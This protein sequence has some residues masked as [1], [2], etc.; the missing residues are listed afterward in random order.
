MKNSPLFLLGTLMIFLTLAMARPV[1]AQLEPDEELPPP[2]TEEELAQLLAPIA[3]YPDPL[4]S[5]ILMASTYP[6]EIV[7]AQRWIADNPGLSGEE[8][9]AHLVELDW[10]PSVK[11]LCHF[12]LILTMMSERLEQTADLGNAFLFQED[13]VMDVVQELRA[14]AHEAGNLADSSEQQVI[15]EEE[16]IIIEPA[17]PRVIYVP[18]YNPSFVYGRWRYPDYPPYYWVPGDMRVGSGIS[19]WPGHQFHFVFGSWSL[20][21]WPRRTLYVDPF[22]RPGFVRHDRWWRERDGWYH[23]PRYRRGSPFYRRPHLDSER[24]PYYRRDRFPDPKPTIVPP[25]RRPEPVPAYPPI[26]RHQSPPDYQENQQEWRRS[27]IIPQPQPP[28]VQPPRPR[29]ETVPVRPSVRRHQAPPDYQENQ[30]EWRRTVIIPQPQPTVV[31]PPQP[32]VVVQPPMAQPPRPLPRG[33]VREQVV[34]PP[35]E[36]ERLRI[37]WQRFNNKERI[38]PA[39][40]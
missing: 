12:P 1:S 20:F 18:L 26:R 39:R 15:V 16:T 29:P 24:R 8:L 32:P 23:D 34:E 28:V 2:F 7:E 9:D 10:A 30:Q 25:P 6:I 33:A 13:E 31:P 22:S 19:Y 38:P 37:D 17:N 3:L 35:S 36:R 40:R 21:D 27:V 11:A 4:L 5:Q 14:Q